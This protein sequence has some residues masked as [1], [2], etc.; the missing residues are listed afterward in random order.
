MNFENEIIKFGRVVGVGADDG[1][2][3]PVWPTLELLTGG[4]Y[5]TWRRD[6]GRFMGKIA[7]FIL[8]DFIAW[9]KSQDLKYELLDF[10]EDTIGR[11]STGEMFRFLDNGCAEAKGA[12]DELIHGFYEAITK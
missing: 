3:N 6:N 10:M 12:F 1:E 4:Y 7:E 8:E 11:K 2:G 5:F 9:M